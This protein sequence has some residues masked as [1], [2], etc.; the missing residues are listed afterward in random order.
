MSIDPRFRNIVFGGSSPQDYLK[1]YAESLSNGLRAV[2][3]DALASA[4]AAI[5]T[6]AENGGTLYLAGNG[7]SAAICD[8][9]V[10][11]FVKG[12]YHE[13]HPTVLTVS[14]TENVA[15]YTAVANDFGFEGVFAFQV[16]ARMKPQDV[17]LA[18]SSSGTSQNIVQA[19]RAAKDIGATT[20][21]LS[22]FSGGGLNTD[23]DIS[24]HVPFDNYGVVEDAHSALLHVMVQQISNARDGRD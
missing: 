1:D 2:D 9:L 3:G 21:G 17:L 5:Q 8:H 7:G 20:I 23:S 4:I 13:D 18:V 16:K 11:D 15:L 14:M 10:C 24:L 12:T 19:I 22:G 6:C